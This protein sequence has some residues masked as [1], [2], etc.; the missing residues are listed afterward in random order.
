VKSGIGRF[1][2][3]F[4]TALHALRE[5]ADERSGAVSKAERFGGPGNPVDAG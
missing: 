3:A 5:K 4:V 2:I 1:P